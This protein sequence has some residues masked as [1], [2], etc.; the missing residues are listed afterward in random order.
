MS[1]ISNLNPTQTIYNFDIILRIYEQIHKGTSTLTLNLN[2][3]SS[4]KWVLNTRIINICNP[5][6]FNLEG[7]GFLSGTCFFSSYNNN[8]LAF[9]TNSGVLNL[10]DREFIMQLQGTQNPPPNPSNTTAGAFDTTYNTN[11]N[12]SNGTNKCANNN[13]NNNQQSCCGGITNIIN[14]NNRND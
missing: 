12:I 10:Y 9:D 14:L 4:Y 7:I 5:E 3:D 11:Y 8:I 1:T 13:H 2:P 6:L